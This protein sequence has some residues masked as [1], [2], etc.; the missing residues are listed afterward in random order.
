MELIDWVKFGLA[1]FLAVVGLIVLGA[2]AV[3]R[4]IDMEEED[5]R[6]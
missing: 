5:G 6:R 2:W 3:F 4:A 1:A